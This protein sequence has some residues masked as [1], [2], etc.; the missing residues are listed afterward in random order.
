MAST[1]PAGFSWHALKVHHHQS[2]LLTAPLTERVCPVWGDAEI[3]AQIPARQRCDA[4]LAA[5]ARE[6]ALYYA[7][8]GR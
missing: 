8:G 3:Q 6:L 5:V 1:H 7:L 2:T 4:E